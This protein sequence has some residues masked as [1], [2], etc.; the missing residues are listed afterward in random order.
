MNPRIGNPYYPLVPDYNLLTKEG[1][2]Q[3]RVAVCRDDSSA[4][5]YITGHIFFRSHYLAPQGETFYQEGGLLPT[6]PGHI[7]MLQDYCRFPLCVEAFPRGHGKSTIFSK[8]LPLREVVCFPFRQVVVCTASEKLVADKAA[9]VMIQL[10]ENGLILDDFGINGRLVPKKGQRRIFNKTYMQLLNGSVLEELTIGSRQRGTRA[11][12]YILDDP[13]FDPDSSKQERHTE[14]RNKLQKFIEHD[15]LYMLNPKK[16][17]FFWIGTMI[18]ARSYLYHVC[19]SKEKKYRSWTRRV[20]SGAVIDQQ[21]GK[22]K[23]G[24]W[25]ERFPVKHLQM[26]HDVNSAAFMTEIQNAPA[27]EQARLLKLDPTANEYTVDILPTNLD[28]KNAAHLPHPDA[29]MTYHYFTGYTDDMKMKWQIDHVNQ[30]EHFDNMTRIATFDYAENNSSTSDLKAL[31]IT[32]IDARNA[33]WRL[34][35]WAG[36]MK[37]ELFWDFM[38]KWCAAWRVHIIA[39]ETSA[40]QKF[41]VETINRRMFEGNETR[42]IPK[43]WFPQVIPV[44]YPQGMD[45]TNKGYRINNSFAYR[46]QKGHFKVPASYQKKWPFNEERNQFKFFTIDLSELKY[47]DIIDA[48]AMVGYVPHSKGTAAPTKGVNQEQVV[49]ENIR[50][51]KPFLKGEEG[52]VGM[53]LHELKPAYLAALIAQRDLN[54]KPQADFTNVWDQPVVVG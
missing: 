27:E 39:P 19:F 41:L 14:L 5:A 24:A 31:A 16:M 53:P 44:N 12:R 45:N 47:D 18:G 1:K 46:L 40:R 54:N 52:L 34:D 20:Q 4:T 36:R 33:W 38:I 43:D 9:P 37:D 22:I 15:V 10:E 35:L 48:G 3:A 28:S 32:G 8:E 50:Q 11:S 29:I 49:I 51:G 6:A 17:K 30:K 23:S 26:L 21:S 25:Q 13:E 2:R 7:L 42:L